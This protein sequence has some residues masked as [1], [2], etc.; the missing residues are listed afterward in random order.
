MYLKL[1]KLKHFYIYGWEFKLAL[2]EN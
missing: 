1:L 2:N